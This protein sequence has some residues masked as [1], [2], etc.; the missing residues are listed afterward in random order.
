MKTILIGGAVAALSLS[1]AALANERE[2]VLDRAAAFAKV[3][4]DDDSA[5]DRGEFRA[6]AMKE[7][8]LTKSEADKLFA[9]IAEKNDA[10]SLE[11]YK[12]SPLLTAWYGEPAAAAESAAKEAAAEA[13]ETGEAKMKAAGAEKKAAMVKK[14]EAEM[15]AAGKAAENTEEPAPSAE[16]AMRKA[17]AGDAPATGKKAEGVGEKATAEKE[18]MTSAAAA[19]AA[20]AVKAEAAADDRD[21]KTA[22]RSDPKAERKKAFNSMDENGD[23]VIH[24]SEYMEYV[25]Q[26][27]EQYFGEVAGDDQKISFA[28]FEKIE[29]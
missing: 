12:N 1:G 4:A 11:A 8:K 7:H 6:Y 21:R 23:G 15:E 18:R 24:K 17:A 22:D 10:I 5:L 19:A 9:D 13:N 16:A 26:Q 27:A 28:E 14:P 29:N 2:D 3:D 20:P 25:R